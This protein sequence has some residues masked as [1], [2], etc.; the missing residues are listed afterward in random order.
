MNKIQR[1]TLNGY[2][3]NRK[4]EG[5]LKGVYTFEFLWPMISKHNFRYR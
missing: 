1:Q 4:Y 5:E 3:Q 2:L